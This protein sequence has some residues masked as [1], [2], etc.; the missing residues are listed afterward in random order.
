[1]EIFIGVDGGGTKT[2]ATAINSAGEVL[3]RYT[4]GSTNPYIVTF[5]KAMEE[6]RTVLDGLLAPLF[7]KSLLFTS[8]C[9]GMSGVSSAEERSQV[10]SFLHSYLQQRQLSMHI[11]MRSEA[12]ISLMAVLERQYG[13][14][15]ISG[16]GSNT[17]AIT[18]SGDIHRVGG[19]GH[20]L[21]D[22]GSGYQIGLQTLKTVIK[23]HEG[24]LPPTIMSSLIVAAYPLQHITDLKSYI[25]QPAITKQDIASFARCCIEAAEA[26]DEAA[27]RILRQ[28]AAE[29][30][31]TTSALIRQQA[32][33]AESELVRIGSIFKHS[34]L[35]RETYAGILLSRY[36]RLQFPEGNRERTPAHGAALLACKLFTDG[37][38]DLL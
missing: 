1:M 17:Y 4:G 23:S 3:S 37:V 29:L 24:I 7:D 25:Y 5:N 34:P 11:Y 19:W 2:E 12:E 27:D 16:T 18:K 26:G 30:A 13:I 33:F 32:E 21:G 22:E 14:L 35:F 31:D 6:L 20:L 15:A 36:P 9:L 8:I 38:S 28:Q 10:Q